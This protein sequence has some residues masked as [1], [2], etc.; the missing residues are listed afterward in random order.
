MQI[1]SMIDLSGIYR[2]RFGFILQAMSGPRKITLIYFKVG[3]MNISARV[4]AILCVTVAFALWANGCVSENENKEMGK[5][6]VEAIVRDYIK[7]NPQEITAAVKQFEQQQR[8][9]QEQAQLNQA[10]QQRVEVPIGS[11]PSQG[12]SDAPI[13]IVEFSDFQ[14]PFCA[15]SVPTI[16]ALRANHPDQTRLVFKN[17]PLDFH[18]QAPA[19]HKA[20]MAAGEQGKFWEYRQILMAHQQEWA[21]EVDGKEKF[22]AYATQLEMDIAKF[23]KDMQNPEYEKVMTEDNALAKK[24]G[25]Q[26][27][28]TY[29]INGAMVVGARDLGY[30]EKVLSEVAK[31]M[32]IK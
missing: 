21:K 22:I 3:I 28:P 14:C 30:F 27:T 4:G 8:Q 11:S 12:P 13:T 23:E 25:V 29:F 16:Q 9:A 20:A 18:T 1:C 10:L 31:S 5:A 32:A 26:G 24:L 17:A 19:A 6:E 7:N 2:R 15:R